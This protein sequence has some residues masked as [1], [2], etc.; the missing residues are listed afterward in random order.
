MTSGAPGPDGAAAAAPAPSPFAR[1]LRPKLPLLLVV[2]LLS[3]LLM[4]LL[5]RHIFI[6]VPPGE[7]GVLFRFFGGTQVDRVYGE[8]LH[9]IAPWNRM[10]LYETRRQVVMHDFEVLSAPGLPLHLELAIRFQPEREQLPLLHQRIGPEYPRRVVIPQT[11]SVLRRELSRYTAEQVYTNA[12]G[13]L[14]AAILRARDEVGRNFVVT[15]EIVIRSITLPTPIKAAIEDKLAQEQLM[16]S[17]AFRL[18][19]AQEEAQRKRAEA[20]GVRDYQATV[21]ST[22]SE[23]LLH[24]EGISATRDLATSANTRVI[25]L[26]R[27][28][29]GLPLV[30]SGQ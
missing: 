25:M 26:G 19:T 28:Q 9:L 13:L 14:A 24:H 10:F 2:A 30:P 1:W 18:L 11:E 29:G 15:D 23:R 7:A 16:Q 20:R 4:I 5:W 8:G 3:L 21:D 6:S 12:G 27:D 22:L 17:Y